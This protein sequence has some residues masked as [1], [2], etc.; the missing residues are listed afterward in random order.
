MSEYTIENVAA[1]CLK[2]V[3]LEPAPHM[4]PSLV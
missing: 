1:T 2:I 4:Q 3:G